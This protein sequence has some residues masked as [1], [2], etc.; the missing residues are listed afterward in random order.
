M[1]AEYTSEKDELIASLQKQNELLKNQVHI[2]LSELTLAQLKS[3]GIYTERRKSEVPDNNFLDEL[4]RLCDTEIIKEPLV[5]KTE[6]AESSK[7]RKQR[8]PH[9]NRQALPPELTREE[10]RLDIPD[11]DKICPCCQKEMTVFTEEVSEVL[12]YKAAEFYV[13]KTVRPKYACPHHPEEGVVISS[14]PS[15]IIPKGIPSESLLAHLLVSK[16]VDH[17]PL[18]RLSS[19]LGR[20]GVDVAKSSMAD[21][22]QKSAEAL[23]PLAEALKNKVLDCRIINAD[24]TTYKVQQNSHKI[25]K[26]IIRGYLWGYIGNR[27]YVFFEWQDSRSGKGPLIFLKG[28]AGDYLQ[29]DAYSGY[30]PF[31]KINTE[32]KSVG[33]MAHVRRNFVEADTTKDPR[34]SYYIQQIQKL[35]HLEKEIKELTVDEINLRRQAEAIPV[36]KELKEKAEEEKKSVLPK[37]LLGKAIQY[38]LNQWVSLC[39][40]CEDGELQID[41]NIIERSIRPIAIGRKNWLFSGSTEGAKASA[42]IYSLIATCHLN[43]INPAEYLNQTLRLIPNIHKDQIATLLPDQFYQWKKI[44]DKKT[45]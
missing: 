5:E 19:I 13:K 17:L 34:A 42:I 40:Y 25:N 32:I 38:M 6:P 12:E 36:L 9:E 21:W 33:C 1:E 7:S 18:D 4:G 28:Y 8:L 24:E 39:R 2:L 22:V 20:I 27:K 16:Y 35:Y 45:I 29:T 14:L 23:K 26:E 15:R 10:I 11:E 41:N 31:L 3:L 43:N 30:N 37:S 44:L